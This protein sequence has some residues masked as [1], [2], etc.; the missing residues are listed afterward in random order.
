MEKNIR[1]TSAR[2]FNELNEKEKKFLDERASWD[3]YEKDR[4]EKIKARMDYYDNFWRLYKYRNSHPEIKHIVEEMFES[5]IK[6]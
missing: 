5:I 4:T 6:L 3:K 1:E 2:E